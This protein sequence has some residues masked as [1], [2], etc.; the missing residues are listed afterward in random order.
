MLWS[1][2]DCSCGEQMEKPVSNLFWILRHYPQKYTTKESAPVGELQPVA[3]YRLKSNCMFST[4]KKR[5]RK[6]K[7]EPIFTTFTHQNFITHRGLSCSVQCLLTYTGNVWGTFHYCFHT[8]K[9][10]R[11]WGFVRHDESITTGTQKIWFPPP[12]PPPQ[13]PEKSEQTRK[14][15]LLFSSSFLWSI[16]RVYDFL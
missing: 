4:N 13:A 5:K 2:W 12:P 1:E 9:R 10:Q 6:E 16:F 3:Q 15:I 11:A 8:R 14:R 7:K